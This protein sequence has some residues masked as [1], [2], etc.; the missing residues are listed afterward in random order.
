MGFNSVFK[1]LINIPYIIT[2]ARAKQPGVRIPTDAIDLSSYIS[3]M[4][5]RYTY[6]LSNEYRGFFP[7]CKMDGA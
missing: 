2:K 4:A 3:R 6:L 5:L 1:G 7:E